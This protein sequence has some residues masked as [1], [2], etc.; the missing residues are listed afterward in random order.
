MA[1]YCETDNRDLLTSLSLDVHQAQDINS[2]TCSTI[3]IP[4]LADSEQCPLLQDY[5]KTDTDFEKSLISY[6][7]PFNSKLHN[8]E[9]EGLFIEKLGKYAI[10]IPFP[11]PTHNKDTIKHQTM[12]ILANGLLYANINS[13]EKLAILYPGP[14]FCTDDFSEAFYKS[15]FI[16]FVEKVIKQKQKIFLNEIHIYVQSDQIF[17]TLPRDL[18]TIGEK[19]ISKDYKKLCSECELE[20]R[21]DARLCQKCIDTYPDDTTPFPHSKSKHS[22]KE[23]T[24][25]SLPVKQPSDKEVDSQLAESFMYIRRDLKIKFADHHADRYLGEKL[26]TFLKVKLNISN[27]RIH[28]YS[29]FWLIGYAVGSFT[30]GLVPKNFVVP[31][32][33]CKVAAGIGAGTALCGCVLSKEQLV[34]ILK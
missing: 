14:F 29:R 22:K 25:S 21:V 4:V 24:P 30:G 26:H 20:V 2:I 12:L 10:T 15:L 17:E 5:I 28:K 9:P 16:R 34:K 3:L 23:T 32:G 7:H 27:D 13:V 6:L 11:S 31:D 8:N 18:A 19:F 1:K 33:V